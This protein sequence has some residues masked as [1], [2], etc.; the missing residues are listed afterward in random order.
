MRELILQFS[1]YSLDDCSIVFSTSQYGRIR[2]SFLE[3]VF[4][5]IRRED[6]F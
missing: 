6:I 5:F 1:K 3:N 4:P 2:E